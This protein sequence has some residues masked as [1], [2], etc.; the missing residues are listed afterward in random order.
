MTEAERDPTFAMQVMMPAYVRRGMRGRNLDNRDV[1]VHLTG[2]VLLTRGDIDMVMPKPGADKLFAE[3]PIVET[4]VYKDTGHLPFF[5]HA[6][7]FNAELADFVERTRSA[8]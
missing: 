8:H 7:R 2:P 6:D 1:L 4:S 5:E 3:L